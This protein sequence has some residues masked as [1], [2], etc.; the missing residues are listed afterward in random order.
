MQQGNSKAKCIN[1]ITAASFRGLLYLVHLH[2]DQSCFSITSFWISSWALRHS[3]QQAIENQSC[4]LRS[5]LMLLRCS[6]P[7]IV[8]HQTQLRNMHYGWDTHSTCNIST[9]EGLKMKAWMPDSEKSAWHWP[10][11]LLWPQHEVESE[12]NQSL[13]LMWRWILL[14]LLPASLN[15]TWW[16]PLSTLKD[17]LHL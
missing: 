1:S 15:A 12:I 3:R 8:H 11:I 7:T 5:A 17:I 10:E 2:F 14:S 6:V 4:R 16:K 13:S 9:V